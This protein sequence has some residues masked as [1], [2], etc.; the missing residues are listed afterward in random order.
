M[1]GACAHRRGTSIL[2]CC[3]LLH[4]WG[5][6]PRGII[7]KHKGC[8]FPGSPVDCMSLQVLLIGTLQAQMLPALLRSKPVVLHGQYGVLQAGSR[9]APWL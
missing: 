9:R 8:V 5:H 1:S 2:S 6:V 7:L 4:I 3:G